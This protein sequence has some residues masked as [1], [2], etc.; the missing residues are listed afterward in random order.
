ML[1]SEFSQ[2][3]KIF[4]CIK[5]TICNNC[6]K[7]NLLGDILNYGGNVDNQKDYG[8]TGS[9]FKIIPTVINDNTQLE[10]LKSQRNINNIYKQPDEINQI[11]IID[12]KESDKRD[13]IGEKKGSNIEYI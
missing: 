8:F 1:L 11:N 9:F 3:R 6:E 4:P 7:I 10:N 13:K 5:T 12:Y 2:A